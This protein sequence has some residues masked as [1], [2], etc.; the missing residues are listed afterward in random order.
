MIILPSPPPPALSNTNSRLRT[1]YLGQ[2]Q[3]LQ[4]RS[5]HVAIIFTPS[6]PPTPTPFPSRIYFSFRSCRPLPSIH[7][8]SLI[9]IFPFAI[10]FLLHRFIHFGQTKDNVFVT[11]VVSVQYQ[12]IK[13]KVRNRPRFWNAILR[14]WRLSA[15]T[16]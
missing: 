5:F 9:R 10:I 7:R 8:A 6:V 12:P 16:Q 4:S 14:F 11:A 2:I 15:M 1:F 13:S 3:Y